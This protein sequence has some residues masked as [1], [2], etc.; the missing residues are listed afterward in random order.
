MAENDITS[1]RPEEPKL[2]DRLQP[3]RTLAGPREQRAA[4]AM[5]MCTSPRLCL[6]RRAAVWLTTRHRRLALLRAPHMQPTYCDARPSRHTLPPGGCALV[7]Q[8]V[9]RAARRHGQFATGRVHDIR[10]EFKSTARAAVHSAPAPQES[11]GRLLPSNIL[12]RPAVRLH[13]CCVLPQQG[14]RWQ[15]PAALGPDTARGPRHVCGA[16]TPHQWRCHMQRLGPRYT[17]SSATPLRP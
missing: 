17:A 14:G 7:C 6:R 5:L 13:P 10:H 3:S 4:A 16:I 8:P 9:E 15:L 12:K 11:A 2:A 1:K